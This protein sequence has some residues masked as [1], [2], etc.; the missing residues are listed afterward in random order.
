MENNDNIYYCPFCAGSFRAEEVL[1][2][3]EDKTG[4]VT[5]ESEYDPEQFEFQQRIVSFNNTT[6]WDG[7][8]PIQIENRPKYKY[9]RWHEVGSLPFQAPIS[10]NGPSAIPDDIIVYRSKGMTPNQLSGK[11]PAPWEHVTRVAEE[12][13]PP[14]PETKVSKGEALRNMLLSG[15]ANQQ[16]AQAAAAVEQTIMPDDVQKTLTNKACPRCHCLLPD[17]FGSVPTYRISMLGGTASG[18]TTYMVAVANL[19]DKMSGLP[20][21]VINGCQI[22]AESK[23][24]FDY[25]I[26]CLEH[27]KLSSTAL[28]ESTFIRFVFP[29]VLNMTTVT[30]DGFGE[31]QFILIINDIPGEAMESKDFLMT[32]PGLLATNAAIMLLDPVQFAGTQR[33]KAMIQS[34]MEAIH[35]D[36]ADTDVYNSHARSFTPTTFDKTLGHIKAMLVQ[37]KFSQLSSLTMVLNKIDLL[38]GR[39]SN[40]LDVNKDAALKNVNGQNELNEQHRDGMDMV[41][42]QELSRQVEHIIEKKLE[43]STYTTALRPMVQNLQHMVYTLCI[44]IRS[45]NA[46]KGNFDT[47]RDEHG[48]VNASEIIGFRMME[49]LLVSLVHLGLVRTKEHEEPEPEE[50]VK[51]GFWSRLFGR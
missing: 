21:G 17:L 47:L 51:K 18:K 25:L 15:M 26:K 36:T 33:K 12:E 27:N 19:L 4:T 3:D 34:D 9:H 39:K 30:D 46:G 38:Y 5:N 45:W 35:L 43:Y 42:V 50:T 41:F 22:S 24:Y 48:Y 14:E 7:K 32:Y 23:R 2:V 13:K 20:S 31:R 10:F 8:T 6:E 40:V 44:S 11:E 16:K 29:I 28:E 49:P 37:D 1:F